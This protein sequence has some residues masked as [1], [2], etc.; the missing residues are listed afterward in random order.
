MADKV[1]VAVVVF[2]EKTHPAVLQEVVGALA[3]FQ[4]VRGVAKAEDGG[5]YEV[6]VPREPH[7]PLWE[8]FR[9]LDIKFEERP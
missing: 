7:E 9:R 6:D 8:A 5:I 3:L 1:K 4:G 2:D